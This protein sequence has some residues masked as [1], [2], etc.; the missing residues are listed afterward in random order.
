MLPEPEDC[1]AGGSQYPGLCAIAGCVAFEFRQPVVVVDAGSA[2]VLR[3]AVPEAPVD[4]NGDAALGKDN[5][6]A[7]EP[8]FHSDRMVLEKAVTPPMQSRAD[9]GFG[10]GVAP[11]DGGHIAGATRRR[12]VALGLGVLRRANVV[13]LAHADTVRRQGFDEPSAPAIMFISNVCSSDGRGMR[14]PAN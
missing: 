8:A 11:P 1:P 9:H 7:D 6:W 3:A 14:W 4:E 10:L 5:V 12:D 2:A 13:R